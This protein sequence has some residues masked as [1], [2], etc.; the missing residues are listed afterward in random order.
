MRCAH[1]GKGWLSGC[2]KGKVIGFL[3]VS[4]APSLS[5]TNSRRSGLF[6]STPGTTLSR[7][8]NRPR[9]SARSSRCRPRRRGAAAGRPSDRLSRRLPPGRLPVRA[10]TQPAHALSLRRQGVSCRFPSPFGIFSATN[11][12]RSGWSPR[13]PA[14]PDGHLLDAAEREPPGHEVPIDPFR[15]PGIAVTRKGAC[16]R[17]PGVGRAAYQ[18]VSAQG[19]P[20]ACGSS[21]PRSTRWHRSPTTKMSRTPTTASLRAEHCTA[22]ERSP[23]TTTYRF[24]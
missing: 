4:L 8:G 3:T 14:R 15:R 1:L 13:P 12:F 2:G 5:T 24:A 7:R 16:G 21:L 9:G 11:S 18:R 20:T 22:G 17:R 19:L 6:R 23:S 10:A